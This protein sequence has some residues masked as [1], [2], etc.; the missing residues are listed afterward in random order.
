MKTQIDFLLD[1]IKKIKNKVY[2]PKFDFID[3]SF[4]V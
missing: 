4:H 3:P 2:N 1:R